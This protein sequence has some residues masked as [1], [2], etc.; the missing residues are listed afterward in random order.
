MPFRFLLAPLAAAFLWAAN[1][2]GAD[3]T[4]LLHGHIYTGD[5]THPW[6]QAVAI[7]GSHIE[8]VG[9]DAQVQQHRRSG[10]HVVD[11]KGRTV[12][13]GMIDSHMHMFFGAMEL[14]GFNLSEPDHSVTPD[15]PEALVAAIKA[16]ADQHREARILIGR[17]DFN[18]TPP[19]VPTAALLDR[20]V[21]DRP[22]IVHCTSEHAL[23]V[24]SAALKLAGITDEPVADPEE[25]RNVIRDASGHPSGLLLEAAQELMA[26]A[27]L[28]QLSTEEKL[29]L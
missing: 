17:A 4:L 26:R 29:A 20:A 14:R 10:A 23:W 6:A 8:A 1:A 3:T 22:V 16:F 7:N 2:H 21:P 27:V 19:D 18:T 25:E 11:L 15:H 9:S 13:P 12:I 5:T 24:N 28:K